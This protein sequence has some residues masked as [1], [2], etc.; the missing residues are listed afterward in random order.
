MGVLL[1]EVCYCLQ[2]YSI[3]L[4]YNCRILI[5]VLKSMRDVFFLIL[6]S[7]PNI[8]QSNLSSKNSLEQIVSFF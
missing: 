3:Y 6:E 8:K 7:Y 1:N 2:L 5:N 4:W